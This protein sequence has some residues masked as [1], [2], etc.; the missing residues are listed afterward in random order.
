MAVGLYIDDATLKTTTFTPAN[1]RYICVTALSEAGNRGPWTSISD[2]NV[3]SAPAPAPPA[4]TY[5]SWDLTVDFPLVPVSASMEIGTGRLLV[6]SAWNPSQ[7]T[8]GTGNQT[9]TATYDL[10]TQMVSEAVITNTGHDMF[11]EGL[12][13]DSEGRVVA[14]GGTSNRGTSIYDPVAGTWSDG[15]VSTHPRQAFPSG[16]EAAAFRIGASVH[17][18]WS[19]CFSA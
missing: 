10:A 19:T 18:P 5:G 13:L 3:F 4:A 2:I 1:A 11:C 8:G 6:W 7:Y 17:P 16:P 9:V 14:A 15:G 12:S